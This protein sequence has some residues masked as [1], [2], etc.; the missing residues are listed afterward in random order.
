MLHILCKAHPRT[1]P[2]TPSIILPGFRPPI[3][4]TNITIPRTGIPTNLDTTLLIIPDIAY[5][6]AASH[7]LCRTPYDLSVMCIFRIRPVQLILD[8]PTHHLLGGVLR[9]PRTTSRIL[10][11]V[12][13]ILY[14]LGVDQ[15]SL[16]V[17]PESF[18]VIPGIVGQSS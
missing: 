1:R 11:K 8:P 2:S 7:I 9:T 5:A 18:G 3:P 13:P 14:V 16:A 12:L 15:R 4:I 6:L 17:V 10:G